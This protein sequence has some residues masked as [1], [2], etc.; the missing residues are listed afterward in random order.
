MTTKLLAQIEELAREGWCDA[1]IGR[2]VGIDQKTVWRWRVKA[3]LTPG[4]KG[5]QYPAKKYIFYNRRTSE[6]LV[7]GTAKECA[8]FLGLKESSIYS[9][10][11]HTRKG[12]LKKYEIFVVEEGE[13][14]GD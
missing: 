12:R 13:H 10:I 6:F 2:I 7:E 1:E 11:Y 9:Q 8:A 4:K 3:G 14:D 5:R